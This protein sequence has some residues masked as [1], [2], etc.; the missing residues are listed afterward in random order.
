MVD[1]AL[2]KLRKIFFVF[3]SLRQEHAPTNSVYI[4]ISITGEL[5]SAV[6]IRLSIL[7]QTQ[8]S[9][10]LRLPKFHLDTSVLTLFDYHLINIRSFDVFEEDS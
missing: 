3:C 6:H 9:L 4:R 1:E 8:S 10:C 7:R 2:E 5:V